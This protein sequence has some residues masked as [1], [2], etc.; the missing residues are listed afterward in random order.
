VFSS[1]RRAIGRPMM[2]TSDSATL[3]TTLGVCSRA[4]RTGAYAQYTPQN[5]KMPMYKPKV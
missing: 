4:N 1:P 5:A 2:V 3:S